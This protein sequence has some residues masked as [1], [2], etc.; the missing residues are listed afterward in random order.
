MV[1]HIAGAVV[2]NRSVL[3]DSSYRYTITLQGKDSHTGTTALTSRS[4][5]LL[6]A[7][8]MIIAAREV[9]HAKGGLA[10]MGIIVASP[11]STNT[12]PGHVRFSLDVR[13]KSDALRD[14]ICDELMRQFDKIAV[15]DKSYAVDTTGMPEAFPDKLVDWSVRVDSTSTAVRFDEDCIECVRA[16]AEDPRSPGGAD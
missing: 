12:I 1:S 13:A 3:S 11:G 4:D 6:A 7:S 9:A 15:A 14:D 2:H 5:A 8:R 10:T 16:G